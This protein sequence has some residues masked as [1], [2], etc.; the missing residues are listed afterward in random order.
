MSLCVLLPWNLANCS[1]PDRNEQVPLGVATPPVEFD[2]SEAEQRELTAGN[3][4]FAFALYASLRGTSGNLFYSPHSISLALAL[5]YAGAR[6]ETAQQIAAALR[7]SLPAV[8]LHPAFHGLDSA[9]SG[10][11]AA[12]GFEMHI[13]NALWGQQGYDFHR[14]YLSTISRHY[15]A[16]LQQLDFMNF[17]DR[18]RVHIN[19]WV[20][21]QTEQ[22]IAELIPAGAIRIDTRLVLSNAIY[23]KAAWQHPF[24]SDDSSQ[25]VF[26]AA[27]GAQR[28]VPM[29]RQTE[30]FAYASGSG[31][32]ALELPYTAQGLAMLILLPAAGHFD[33]VEAALSSQQVMALSSGQLLSRRRVMLTMPKFEFSEDLQLS[34]ALSSL[35]MP[36]AFSDAADFSALS[37]GELSISEVVHKAFISVD[38]AGTEAAAATAVMM[39]LTSMPLHE[40]TV[41]LRIDRPFIFLIRDQV[42]GT[43]LFLGRV[44]D[45]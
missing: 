37:E 38:E 42:T 27:G 32:Q 43:V 4:D 44:L 35:G 26:H 28:Q 14:D 13:A 31:Y 5:C 29:M 1:Q 6:G 34:A 16:A 2:L 9:L 25:G 39:R 12:A 21:D 45:V 15:G 20:A 11:A 3:R 24:D 8:R 23:F 22:R 19:R 30:H 33:R 41:E 10:R 40:P 17:P 7:F 18:S 36:V